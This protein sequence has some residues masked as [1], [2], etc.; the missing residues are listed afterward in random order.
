M[1]IPPQ[2]KALICSDNLFA[3]KI[4]LFIYIFQIW[5]LKDNST[6][7]LMTELFEF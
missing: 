6:D 5:Y 2:K 1:I 4:L 3:V 7:E